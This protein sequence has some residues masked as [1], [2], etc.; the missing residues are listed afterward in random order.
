MKKQAGQMIAL[1]VVLAVLLVGFVALKNYNEEQ[2]VKTSEDDS[3]A[4]SEIK[5][6]E[7]LEISYDYQGENYRFEKAEGT[8]YY[9]ADHNISIKQYRLENMAS[10]LEPLRALTVIEN[11]TD[12]EQYGL[13]APERSI[14]FQTAQESCTIQVGDLNSMEGGYYIMLEGDDKVYLVDSRCV[15][16]FNFT[17]EDLTEGG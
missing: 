11:V 9:A 15:A 2:A 10:H 6:G 16:V 12:Y 8:W 1:A 14:V 5:E 7:V 4:L 17:L 13:E 3:I